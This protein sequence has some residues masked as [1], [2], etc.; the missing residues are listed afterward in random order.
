MASVRYDISHL[1]DITLL[2]I[3]FLP[4]TR[5]QEERNLSSCHQVTGRRKTL[6]RTGRKIMYSRVLPLPYCAKN[7]MA[8]VWYIRYF[9]YIYDICNS[10]LHIRCWALLRIFHRP[11]ART[12]TEFRSPRTQKLQSGLF[13]RSDFWEEILNSQLYRDFLR[14]I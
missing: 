14:Y 11:A 13:C 10:S 5:W 6:H 1:H 12:L 8:S 4:V 3:I 9:W 2:Y 7:A